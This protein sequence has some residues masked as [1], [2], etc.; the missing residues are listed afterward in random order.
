[1]LT[2]KKRPLSRPFKMPLH[3]FSASLFPSPCVWP[4]RIEWSSEPSVP[5][6]FLSSFFF[7]A[8]SEFSVPSALS[9]FF[10]FQLSALNFQP[11]GLSNF[12]S[13]FYLFYSMHGMLSRFPFLAQP[14]HRFPQAHRQR[15]NGFQPLFSAVRKFAVAIPVNLRQQEFRVSRIPVSGLFN[16]CRSTSPKSSCVSSKESRALSATLCAWRKRLRIRP[17][18]DGRH[19]PS[20]TK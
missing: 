5:N 16:S 6:I 3:F 13:R 15:G 8:H 11:V 7:S 18:A 17:S 12:K 10:S 4:G 9:F 14:A 20:R 2:D 19:P 1:M